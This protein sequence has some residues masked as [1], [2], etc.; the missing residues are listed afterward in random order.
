MSWIN[1]AEDAM[2]QLI[3]GGEPFSADDLLARVGSPDAEH[4]ANGR[5]ST[6]GSL[7]GRYSAGGLIVA[8]GVAASQAPTRRGG[9]IRVWQR[10]PEGGQMRL[11]ETFGAPEPRRR[12]QAP[13]EIRFKPPWVLLSNK[14]GPVAHLLKKDAA[15]DNEGTWRTRCGRYGYRVNV[16]G[17][18]MAKVCHACLSLGAEDPSSPN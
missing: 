4:A 12:K 14:R 10:A 13:D 1:Q 17:Q 16:E 2:R 7:F 3:A 18:P 15:P 5:N 6:I 8:V 11:F 9:M